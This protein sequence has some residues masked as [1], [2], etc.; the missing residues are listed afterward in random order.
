[1]LSSMISN[2]LRQ[3]MAGL[4]LLTVRGTY[5]RGTALLLYSGTAV[6]GALQRD[7]LGEESWR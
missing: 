3:C 5:W 4:S 7:R 1:M 6:L 2:S